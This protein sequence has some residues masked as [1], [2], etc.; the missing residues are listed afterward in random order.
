MATVHVRRSRRLTA[1]KMFVNRQV[2]R[3]FQYRL[4][5]ESVKQWLSS[6]LCS[7]T[8]ME[9]STGS[10][11]CLPSMCEPMA[12][13]SPH[14]ARMH[15]DEGRAKRLYA[16]IN[17]GHPWYVSLQ[18]P[19]GVIRELGFRSPVPSQSVPE[20]IRLIQPGGSDEWSQATK[21][22]SKFDIPFVGMD[23]W[24]TVPMQRLPSRIISTGVG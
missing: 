14:Q 4:L 21:H 16:F 10:Y 6:Q 3:E 24:Q 17:M 15:V 23:V 18:E 7:G 1:L 9:R 20:L 11:A 8:S 13:H 2:V 19:Q 12:R 5:A 22:V